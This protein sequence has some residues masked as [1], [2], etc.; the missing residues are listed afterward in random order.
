[1][2]DTIESFS[3]FLKKIGAPNFLAIG[4]ALIVLW[5]LISGVVRGIKKRKEE[6]DSEGE[7]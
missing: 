4:I 3:E 7:E 2:M 5:L 1:M 6:R